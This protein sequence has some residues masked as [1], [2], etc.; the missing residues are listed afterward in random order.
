M[1]LN[2]A[3]LHGKVQKNTE[4][5]QGGEKNGQ[6]RLK[7]EVDSKDQNVLEYKINF[8]GIFKEKEDSRERTEENY[9]R[10][11]TNESCRQYIY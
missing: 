9:R 6:R 1:A 5:E 2:I 3:L 7:R 10:K 8:R 4:K 11:S